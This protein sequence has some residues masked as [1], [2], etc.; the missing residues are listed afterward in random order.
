[1]TTAPIDRHPA[2]TITVNGHEF[3]VNAA[4]W[5]LEACRRCAGTGHVMFNGFDDICY[6]CGN[7]NN[8]RPMAAESPTA[9][10]AQVAYVAILTRRASA[11][12]R[13]AIKRKAAAADRTA[14]AVAAREVIDQETRLALADH[15][16]AVDATYTANMLANDISEFDVRGYRDLASAYEHGLSVTA[17]GIAA[18][19]AQTAAHI[20]KGNAAPLVEGRRV[21]RG[22]VASVKAVEGYGPYGRP[23]STLKMVL[24]LG[25]GTRVYGTAPSALLGS[26][27]LAKATV[28]LTATVTRSADDPTFGFYSRPAKA[29]RV[30]T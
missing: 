8:Y 30:T 26:E 2:G 13:A 19:E 6:R 14:A 18:A 27:R 20:A 10:A 25:D 16:L 11:R 1:M 24:D 23:I 29:R 4:G 28:E 12:A 21:L 22:T 7:V 5:P 3:T 15:P 9:K 17:E